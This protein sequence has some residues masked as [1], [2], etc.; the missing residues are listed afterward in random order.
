MNLHRMTDYTFMIEEHSAFVTIAHWTHPIVHRYH[1]F[2]RVNFSEHI[3][4]HS[5]RIL[6]SVLF[7]GEFFDNR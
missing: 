3:S 7:V 4:D 2:E 6:L 5:N 1:L